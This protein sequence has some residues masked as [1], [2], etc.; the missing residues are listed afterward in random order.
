MRAKHA[1]RLAQLAVVVFVVV[2]LA[3]EAF[4]L[5]PP[6][7]S[8]FR[9]EATLVPQAP[10]GAELNFTALSAF[11]AHLSQLWVIE[12]RSANLS[13]LNFY[14]DPAYPTSRVAPGDWLRLAVRLQTVLQSQNARTPINLLD[15]A[16]LAQFLVNPADRHAT[17]VLASG[18]LPDT[19]F[20]AHQNDLLTWIREGGAAIWIGDPIGEIIGHA[21]ATTPGGSPEWFGS[22]GAEQFLPPGL[23]GGT[24]YQFANASGA[25]TILTSLYPYGAPG[26]GINSTLLARDHGATL[27][28]LAGGYTNLARVTIG[29]GTLLYV[30]VPLRAPN[31][32]ANVLLDYLDTG[33]AIEPAPILASSSWV[34]DPGVA[35]VRSETAEVHGLPAGPGAGLCVYTFQSDYMATF[36]D[37]RCTPLP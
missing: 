1:R 30:A 27:G 18:I 32:L 3:S 31:L 23:L 26:D 5:F 8:T 16:G 20:N 36:S 10:S 37:L 15:A 22:Q 35:L 19:V 33:L 17:L 29:N 28:G 24:A 14:Y 11:G 7:G 4:L 9:F 25:P 2:L 34:L 21:S 12:N 6:V 13:A